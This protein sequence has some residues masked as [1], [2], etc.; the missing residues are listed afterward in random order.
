LESR[1][2]E[3]K[4]AVR[5]GADEIDTVINRA[6]ALEHNWQCASLPSQFAL[7]VVQWCSTNSSR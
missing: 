7:L 2:L 3:I 1:L 4:L 5:D 6:A